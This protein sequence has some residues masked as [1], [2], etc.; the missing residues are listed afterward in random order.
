MRFVHESG[1]THKKKEKQSNNLQKSN[2][3]VKSSLNAKNTVKGKRRTIA[4]SYWH[5]RNGTLQQHNTTHRTRREKKTHTG[6]CRLEKK[7]NE[8][9]IREWFTAVVQLPHF[10]PHPNS[11]LNSFF[12]STG[13]NSQSEITGFY[14]RP[15]PLSL[16]SSSKKPLFAYQYL[17][18]S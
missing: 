17:A 9:N 8:S 6:R 13:H 3:N 4:N 7:L 11:L 14:R 12:L 10:C 5:Q 15:L 16:L 18:E 1:S 2:F